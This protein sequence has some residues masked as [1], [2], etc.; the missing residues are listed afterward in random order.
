MDFAEFRQGDRDV[1]GGKVSKQ[2]QT[3]KQLPATWGVV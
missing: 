1:G 3:A 2:S